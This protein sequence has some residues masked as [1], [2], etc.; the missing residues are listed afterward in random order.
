MPATDYTHIRP[1]DPATAASYQD[2]VAALAA[3]VND[4]PVASVEPRSLTGAHIPSVIVGRSAAYIDTPTP[5]TYTH[6]NTP[7]PGWNT[8]AGWKVVNDAGEALGGNELAVTGLGI[9]LSAR[10]THIKVRAEVEI[11]NIASGSAGGHYA[12]NGFAC[13]AIQY[14]ATGAGAWSHRA[15]TER[16][17]DSDT[18]N[19]ASVVTTS[20]DFTGKRARIATVLRFASLGGIS[21]GEIRLVTSVLVGDA[22]GVTTHLGYGRIEVETLMAGTLS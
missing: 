10:V 20:A 16:Y 17:Y 19:D 3:T 7:Y 1:G 18:T 6:L 12:R 4:V 13:F 14:R 5:Y 9:T 22:T 2:R 11:H 21:V 8:A 15:V